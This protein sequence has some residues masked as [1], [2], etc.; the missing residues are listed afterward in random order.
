MRFPGEISSQVSKDGFFN[1]HLKSTLVMN[2]SE[3]AAEQYE[4]EL[5]NIVQ[6]WSVTHKGLIY[7]KQRRYIK[8]LIIVYMMRLV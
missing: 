8:M 2:I 1:G 3:P 4:P 6:Y 7:E 5:N